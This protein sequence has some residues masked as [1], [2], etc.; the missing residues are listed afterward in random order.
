MILVYRPM[1]KFTWALFLN[2]SNYVEVVPLPEHRHLPTTTCAI[3]FLHAVN[4]YWLASTTHVC[5]LQDSIPLGGHE[6]LVFLS[7]KPAS[8]PASHMYSR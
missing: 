5:S 2:S 7:L 1:N 6:D 8:Q 3:H 4:T